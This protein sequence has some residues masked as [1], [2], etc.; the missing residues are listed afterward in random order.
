MPSL[1]PAASMRSSVIRDSVLLVA[2]RERTKPPPSLASSCVIPRSREA[3][4]HTYIP[5]RVTS[6]I[7]RR[8]VPHLPPGL[9]KS[10]YHDAAGGFQ[11]TLQQT[12]PT[13][14]PS[15]F[16]PQRKKQYSSSQLNRNT[17]SLSQSAHLAPPPPFDGHFSDP[18][19][20][21]CSWGEK[22]GVSIA[23]C[24]RHA[25]REKKKVTSNINDI[26]IVVIAGD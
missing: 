20:G 6:Y 4:W 25:G 10:T 21:R 2:L 15:S 8:R 1:S 26:I 7:M 12:P 18:S 23:D 16:R 14:P 19:N 9:P 11:I 17:V 3:K 13:P 5:S 22:K 24:G